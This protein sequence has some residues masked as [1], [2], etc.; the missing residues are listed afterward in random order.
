MSS[1]IHGLKSSTPVPATLFEPIW[2][3][4]SEL[5][6]SWHSRFVCSEYF[7]QVGK[8][9]KQNKR[10]P[11]AERERKRRVGRRVL[12]SGA[13]GDHEEIAAAAVSL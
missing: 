8:K 11:S 6:K 1:R 5:L 13:V 9:T 7:D 4:L 3:P 12:P 10:I 2:Q